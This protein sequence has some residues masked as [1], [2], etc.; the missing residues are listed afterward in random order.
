V[1][2]FFPT[3]AGTAERRG[4]DRK[5]LRENLRRSVFPIDEPFNV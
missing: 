1:V 4:R 2:S 3:H 5:K